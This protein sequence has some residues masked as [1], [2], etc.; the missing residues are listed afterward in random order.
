MDGKGVNVNAKSAVFPN[1]ETIEGL[2]DPL[3]PPAPLPAPGPANRPLLPLP[4]PAA[5]AQQE[6]I[7]VV[8][9]WKRLIF[10]TCVL[11]GLGGMLL[12]TLYMG[13]Y[14]TIESMDKKTLPAIQVNVP[15]QPA[16][17]ATP[18]ILPQGGDDN[19]Q[20]RDDLKAMSIKV[21]E[22]LGALGSLGPPQAENI[23]SIQAATIDADEVATAI[24]KK[25]NDTNGALKKDVQEA[26]G[27][28]VGELHNAIKLFN[29]KEPDKPDK[30]A[31]RLEQ[32][33]RNLEEIT[34][35]LRT[36]ARHG[37]VLPEPIESMSL[38]QRVE[39][40]NDFA[41][42]YSMRFEHKNPS[43]KKT[44]DVKWESMVEGRN[45]DKNASANERLM[46][47]L[48][49]VK[50]KKADEVNDELV[51]DACRTFL[52]YSSNP[53]TMQFPSFFISILKDDKETYAK[54][55]TFLADAV[56]RIK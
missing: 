35:A 4:A 24:S 10:L 39:K 29:Q 26:L 47:V 9:T 53:K 42:L 34:F 1:K 19:A 23:A 46:R 31:E 50:D 28:M 11:F 33:L 43:A 41:Q 22:V 14:L 44:W 15:A 18:V 2:H 8:L 32:V 13:H 54:L 30:I 56:N 45:G 20:L 51:Y 52:V 48:S 37:T 38:A 40:L 3:G 36:A 16:A 49:S 12:G 25:L 55:Q 7:V 6:N 5:K 21:D 17:P 27:T